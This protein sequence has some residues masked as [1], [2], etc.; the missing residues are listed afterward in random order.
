MPK[1][2]FYGS[3]SDSWSTPPTNNVARPPTCNPGSMFWEWTG[4][5]MAWSNWRLSESTKLHLQK[6][7][8]HLSSSLQLPLVNVSAATWRPYFEKSKTSQIAGGGGAPNPWIIHGWSMDN[9]WIIHGSSMD[10]PWI[11]HGLAMDNPWIIHGSSMDYP[12]IIHGL[13][14]DNPWIIHG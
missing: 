9:P 8:C 6:W 10:N 2:L 7:Q 13:S 1:F 12:W 4:R 11:I 3:T 14:M 5:S